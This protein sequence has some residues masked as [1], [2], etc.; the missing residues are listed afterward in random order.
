MNIDPLA[1]NSRR[2]NPYN[3][4]YNNPMYFIDPDGMQAADYFTEDGQYLGND[5]VDD[6]KVF[7]AKEGSYKENDKGGYNISKSGISELK[8][9]KGNA[10]D[11]NTFK[12]IAGTIYAEA[13]V[14]AATKDEMLGILDCVENRAIADGNSI[15]EQMQAPGQVVGYAH[16]DRIGTESGSNAQ[17]KTQNA[18]A[19]AIQGLTTNV[20]STKGAYYWDGTDY[21]STARYTQGTTF[22]NASHNVYNLPVNQKAG[23]NAFGSWSSKFETTM[24]SGQTIFSRLT[25]EWRNSQHSTKQA[26]WYGSI[27]K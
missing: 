15:M 7:I 23:S 2:W 13:S 16:R 6:D 26:N 21:S 4:A 18:F 25:T 17:T 1:E 14:G 9:G 8:D 10:V 12:A 24:A 5:G 3:Y 19:A 11:I 22:T 20:D 27:K